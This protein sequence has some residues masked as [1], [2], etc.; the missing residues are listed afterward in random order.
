[1][2]IFYQIL[3]FGC[4][5]QLSFSQPNCNAFLWQGDTAQFT[6]CRLLEDNLNKHYQFSREFHEW[7]DSAIAICP[8]FAY[9]WREKAAPY[10]K[11]GNFLE[12]KKYIDLAVK[13]DSLGYLPVRASLRYKFFADYNG[14]IED[15][16][17]LEKI[18][19]GDI[20]TSSNGTYHLKVVKSL[21]YKKTGNL[22]KAI[23]ILEAHINEENYSSGPYDLLHLG[24]MYL[25]AGDYGMAEKYLELQNVKYKYAET[26]YYLALLYKKIGVKYKFTLYKKE[27]QLLYADNHRMNDTYNH[28]I[29]QIYHQQILKL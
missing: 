10:V 28:L 24:V 9:A 12:W 19:S 3:V 18:Y 8:R 4:I 26:Y 23:Q 6:A 20:G 2:K 7:V 15:I 11:S 29:D 21:C 27:A 16:E 14:A 25:E 13:Y 17:L 5:N 22:P 1:M